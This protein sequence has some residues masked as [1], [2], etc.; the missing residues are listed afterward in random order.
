MANFWEENDPQTIWARASQILNQYVSQE[1]GGAINWEAARKIF[2]QQTAS[3]QGNFGDWVNAVMAQRSSWVGA[4]PSTPPAGTDPA[5]TPPATPTSGYVPKDY[6]FNKEK[7]NDPNHQS[8]K[9]AVHRIINKYGYTAAGLQQALAEIRQLPYGKNARIV[10]ADKIDFG[11]GMWGSERL[12]II[13]VIR[14]VGG[15]NAGG[16]WITEAEAAANDARKKGKT[17]AKAPATKTP[18]TT[19]TPAGTG[20]ANASLVAPWTGQFTAPGMPTSFY[21]QRYGRS[22]T[23]WNQA[24]PDGGGVVPPP[25][26]GGPSPPISPPGPVVPPGATSRGQPGRGV[27]GTP[28]APVT[29]IP[30]SPGSGARPTAAT[31]SA[32]LP[33]SLVGGPI[34]PPGPGNLPPASRVTGTAVSHGP[35]SGARPTAGPGATDPISPPGTG[36]PSPPIT[37][38]SGFVPPQAFPS[39]RGSV[40]PWDPFAYEMFIPPAERAPGY[41]SYQPPDE[42]APGYESYRPVT[43]EDLSQDPSYQF[44]QREA[45]KGIERSAAAQGT[46]LTGGTL[47]DISQ[48]GSDLASTE[49]ANADAR[50]FR[51][52]RTGYERLASEDQTADAR[53]FRNWQTGYGRLASEDESAFTRGLTGWGTN[54]NRLRGEESDLYG[55][56]LGAE[57]TRYGRAWNEYV[58]ARDI[59]EKNR[60]Q[61]YTKYLELAKLGKY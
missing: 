57:S 4:G 11:D 13:D 12:G 8:P 6:L 1:G 59:F 20:L 56:A 36:G 37:P 3:G 40:S 48:Y 45:Q 35:G 28:A 26:T 60:D 25:G 54:Y 58:F 24:T 32:A 18:G 2:E 23:P 53:K 17:V 38:P 41:G 51:D 16:Q 43:A 39:P 14:D 10:G 15:P 52:W 21:E 29:A 34:S 46:L 42:R 30:P 5:G 9:Y 33:S 44:R 19:A 61:A 22:A 49:Y 55:R 50:K 27:P 31:A 7:W 47:K